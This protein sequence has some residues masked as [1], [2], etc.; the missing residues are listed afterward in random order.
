MQIRMHIHFQINIL[1]KPLQ[2]TLFLSSLYISLSTKLM[3]FQPQDYICPR[4]QFNNVLAF[5]L[6][7]FHFVDVNLIIRNKIFYKGKCEWDDHKK[8][9][10]KEDDGKINYI[11]RLLT[12]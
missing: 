7:H 2:G 10:V 8:T 3:S 4:F 6:E 1:L 5:M 11:I 12:V 9:T